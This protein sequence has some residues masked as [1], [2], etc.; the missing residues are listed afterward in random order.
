[1]FSLLLL[2]AFVGFFPLMFL[3]KLVSCHIPADA[4]ILCRVPPAADKST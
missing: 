2:L 4:F 3:R 1:M